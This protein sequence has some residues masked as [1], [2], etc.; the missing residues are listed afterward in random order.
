MFRS[1]DEP[2]GR[3]CTKYKLTM[4]SASIVV[5]IIILIAEVSLAVYEYIHCRIDGNPLPAVFAGIFS[6]HSIFTTFYIVGAFRLVECFMVPWLTLQLIFLTTFVLFVIV[7]WI[8]T[9]LSIFNLVQYYHTTSDK[10]LTNKEFFVLT[11]VILTIV[12]LVSI[13]LSHILYKG[14]VAVRNQNMARYRITEAIQRKDSVL[15]PSYV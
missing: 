6:V 14:F 9:L 1:E 10:G 3:R 15:K 4:R 7:W 2:V 8:A 11:G 5:A 13:K 12:L